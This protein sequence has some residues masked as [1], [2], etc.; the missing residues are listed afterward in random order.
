MKIEDTYVL[1]AY[2]ISSARVKDGGLP[3]FLYLHV[4]E[5]VDA[6]GVEGL[7]IDRSFSF[8]Q[9]EWENT[10]LRK[11]CEASVP[12]TTHLGGGLPTIIQNL[13]LLGRTGRQDYQIFVEPMKKTV[14]RTQ[15]AIS[16]SLSVGAERHHAVDAHTRFLSTM[17]RLNHTLAQ[18]YLLERE[19]ADRKR[20]EAAQNARF[21]NI[22]GFGGEDYC[23]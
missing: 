14:N 12:L 16:A 10:F 13:T 17:N 21:V 6:F 20:Q 1:N 23:P 7:P 8:M 5:I 9:I 22:D 4:N 2:R 15:D 3:N 18:E 19:D 11:K